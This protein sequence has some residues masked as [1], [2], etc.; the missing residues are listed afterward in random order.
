MDKINAVITGVAGYVPNY[1]M[2]NEEISQI[3]DT[4][5]EWI[6]SRIGIKERRILK[7]EEGVGVSH[8]AI[9]AVEELMRKTSLNPLEVNA[10]V[11]ATTTPDYMMPNA[12]SLVS[13]HL[14]MKNAFGFDLSAACSGF[15]FGLEVGSGLITS[16]RHKKVIVIA[17]D[18]LS[19]ITNYEDRNTA[20]IFGDGCGAVLLEPTTENIGIIDAVLRS[21]AVGGISHLSIKAGGSANPAS[22][23]TVDNN[24]HKIYQEGK[25]VFKHA[26]SN[27]S[28]SCVEIMKRNYLTPEDVQWVIPHQANLRIIDAVTRRLE[29]SFSEKV[30]INIEKY[31][32]TSAASIPL[33][34]WDYESKLKKGDNMVLTAFGAG[35]TW[36]AVYLKWGYD[37]K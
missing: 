9:K 30:M 6:M 31:G 33:C 24:E 25:V 1:V 8:M 16:G 13:T 22:H 34:L 29:V 3:V 21:E 32:N 10:V 5:D 17:G 11:F 19:S 14:G 15:I 35:F 36:G 7:K 12:A 23:E 2:T 27:M 26:V 20:P 37:P 4:S 18:M 28:D